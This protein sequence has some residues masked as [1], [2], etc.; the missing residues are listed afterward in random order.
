MKPFALLTTLLLL[1]TGCTG[2]P[3]G[4]EPV[5]GFDQD[6]Y[7]GTWYEIARLDH[8]FERGLSRVTAEYTLNGDGS[9]KVINRGYN[10][11]KSEWKE[12]RGRAKFVGDSDVGHLKVSFFGPFYASYVVFE[13]D[14][15]YSTAYITGY[16]RNYLWLMSRT[17]EVSEEVLEAFKAR[18]AAEGF[19][20]GELIVVKQ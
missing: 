6:R 17:P 18:A 9:I 4:I 20:L 15:D 8:S 10:A 3:K 1:L 12:A 7:L 11:E 19:E 2:L 14:D 5:T 16:N 13:L